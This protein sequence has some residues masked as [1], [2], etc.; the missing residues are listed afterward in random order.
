MEEPVAQKKSM[1]PQKLVQDASPVVLSDI[2][3]QREE[4]FASGFPELDRVLGG[5]IVP[6][7]LPASEN[8][9]CFCKYARS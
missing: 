4:R 2:T 6:A 7:S 5:G 8:L 9:R 1:S 3:L